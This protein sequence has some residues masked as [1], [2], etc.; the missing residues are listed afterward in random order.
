MDK[1][2][3][4]VYKQFEKNFREEAEAFIT[5]EDIKSTLKMESVRF[6]NAE[7]NNIAISKF[8]G[9]SI[10]RY[11]KDMLR[12]CQ[13]L[14]FI[15]YILS[16]VTSFFYC[17]FIWGTVKCTFLYLTGINKEAFSEKIPMS[18]PVI[19]CAV[20]ITCNSLIRFYT[21]KLL[22]SYKGNIKKSISIFSITCYLISVVI[23]VLQ[24]MSLYLDKEIYWSVNL[25]LFQMFIITAALLL[26]SG[27]HNVIYS[28]NFSLSVAICYAVMLR[29]PAEINKA[30]ESYMRFS[31]KI[32]LIKHK[33]SGSS[34]NENSQFK[35]EYKEWIRSH[36]VTLRAY[37]A[38]AFFIAFMLVIIC[39]RQI[40][41]TG[42]SAGLAVF[43]IAALLITIM[44]FLEI[45]SCNQIIKAC[46][47]GR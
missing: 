1:E 3:E 26:A 24:A 2:Y 43:S 16:Q 41:I 21:R 29:K 9:S 28:S 4:T 36:V 27:V 31:F 35:T 7:K 37:G 47:D 12:Q 40:I 11:T 23:L 20:I 25:S 46:R 45:S 14:F 13:P 30:V 42:I 8:T 6:S 39:L 18:M 33:V 32:F 5:E 22:Y 44:L 15:Y 10:A 19:F 34:Y 38:I 17:L